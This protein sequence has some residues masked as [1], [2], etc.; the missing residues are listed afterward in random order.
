MQ[1][2]LEGYAEAATPSFI[3]AYD[4]LSP[5]LIYEHVIDLFPPRACKV[6]DIG[7]GTGRD[8][9]WFAKKGCDVVAV[10]PVRELREAG[11][12]LHRCDKIV[13]RDD[14]LPYLEGMPFDERFDLITLC[15]VWQHLSDGDRAAAIP[16][17]AALTAPGGRVVMS[18]RHGPGGKGRLVFPVSVEA[19][20]EAAARCGLRLVRQ[21]EAESVQE[22]NKTMGVFWTWLVVENVR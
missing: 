18:L 5:E 12:N 11:R 10:E 9:A 14:R 4:K 22:G 15:A 3:A 19:T 2:I 21:R 1:S 13:W 16:R 8:A 6:A 17:L 20:V 7:A